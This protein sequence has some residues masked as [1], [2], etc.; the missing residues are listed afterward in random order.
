MSIKLSIC[1][2]TYNRAAF[3][4]N[5]L[6]SI[7]A[8]ATDEVE[9]VV[10]DNASTDNTEALVNE[11]QNR[12]PRIRYYRNA[13]NL[14]ADRNYLKVVELAQGEYC[15]LLGSDDALAKDAVMT[16]LPRLGNCDIYLVDR[17]NLNFTMD[18]VLEPQQK[19]HGA[20]CGAIYNCQDP[21][22]RL[23]YFKDALHLGS[24]FSYISVLIVRRNVWQNYPVIEDLIG[25]AWIHAAR[26]FQMM[27]GGAKLEYVG[28]PLVL[29]R[30][31]NDSFHATVGYTRRRLIDLDYPRVARAVFSDQPEI[32]TEV[33][34]VTAA[35]YFNLRVLLSDKRAAIEADGPETL[36]KLAAVYH[37]EFAKLPG[38]RLKIMLWHALPYSVLKALRT[39]SKRHLLWLRNGID[40]S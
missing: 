24:L 34:R 19:M 2:P 8:Q 4:S 40:A 23:T 25:S 15:W 1:I 30:T 12:F 11:Y 32:L 3:L 28:I 10:S 21:K 16:M 13:E 5:T 29:N 33:T 6:D 31:D 26:I 18:Q 36:Q 27:H 35:A 22:Q 14:G 9:I 20:A 7:I 37:S 38:Y 39:I 17:A